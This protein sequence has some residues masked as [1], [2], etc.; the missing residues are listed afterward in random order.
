MF[1][2]KCVHSETHRGKRLLDVHFAVAMCHVNLFVNDTTCNVSTPGDLVYALQQR[3]AIANTTAELIGV[4]RTARSMLLW[5]KA[6]KAK[7]TA[8]MGRGNEIICIQTSQGTYHAKSYECSGGE[9]VSLDITQ[10]SSKR[11]VTSAIGGYV[12]PITHEVAQIQE[13][14]ACVDL[15]E[16]E[17][18]PAQGGHVEL[19]PAMVGKQTGVVLYSRGLP[20]RMSTCRK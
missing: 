3:D 6:K 15:S 19:T 1:L 12:E 2:Q 9:G 8:A 10:V 17:Q 4:D 20:R 13:G 5:N 18:L 11:V 7:R 16:R 14:S